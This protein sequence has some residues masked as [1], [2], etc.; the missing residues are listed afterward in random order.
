MELLFL[1]NSSVFL[2]KRR[3]YLHCEVFPTEQ[4]NKSIFYVS[5][6]LLTLTHIATL[7]HRMEFF[8]TPFSSI[9]IKS[10]FTC[11]FCNMA[12]YHLILLLSW[13]IKVS[14]K[15]YFMTFMQINYMMINS[16]SQ[17]CDEKKKQKTRKKN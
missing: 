10:I 7:Y 16:Q 9:E 1:Y 5:C 6:L 11:C 2:R 4:A 13:C 8:K 12:V 3:Q 14:T 15:E 17:L